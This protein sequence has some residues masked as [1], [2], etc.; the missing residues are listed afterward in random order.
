MKTAFDPR[1]RK[2]EKLVQQLFTA[3][4]RNKLPAK[5]KSSDH[6]IA[7]AAPEWPLEKLNAIDLAILR[8][9][10]WELTVD[11]KAPLKVIIDEAV[12]LAKQFG[13]SASPGFVNG[14]LGTICKSLPPSS[15][16]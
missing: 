15:S 1:H 13:G 9:A 6:L 12:E 5:F 8:L 14:V 11:K 10:M 7:A 4:F 2:R 3:S 16:S